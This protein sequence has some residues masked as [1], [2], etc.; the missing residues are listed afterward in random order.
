MDKIKL[1]IDGK[2]VTARSEQTIL[3]VIQ[4]NHIAEI[5]TL[6]HEPKLPPTAPVTC[7]WWRSKGS[8]S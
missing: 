3:E 2:E 5:P 8:T 4:E 1:T 6:C 7:A